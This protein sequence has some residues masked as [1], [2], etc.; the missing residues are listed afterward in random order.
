MSGPFRKYSAP[1]VTRG[2]HVARRM[3]MTCTPQF[4]RD[5]FELI[6]LTFLILL[7]VL[8]VI[9]KFDWYYISSSLFQLFWGGFYRW[10]CCTCCGVFCFVFLFFVLFC[11]VFFCGGVFFVLFFDLS[12]VC[13]SVL[14]FQ[15]IL[16]LF[17]FCF[18]LKLTLVFIKLK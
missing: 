13:F 4:A 6:I 5:N 11:I 10:R 17:L 12:F 8:L 1:Y 15:F 9:Y 16:F 7:L 14:L 18:V 2:P 3:R